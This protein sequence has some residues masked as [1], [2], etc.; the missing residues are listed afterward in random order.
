MKIKAAVAWKPN[1]P[2]SLNEIDFEGP[3]MGE[4]LVKIIA[5]QGKGVIFGLGRIGFFYC[6][7]SALAEE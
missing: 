6:T 5:T 2:L 7:R 4:V 1:E 3:K